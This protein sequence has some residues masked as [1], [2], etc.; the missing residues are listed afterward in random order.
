MASESTTA[1]TRRFALQDMCVNVVNNKTTP[2]AVLQMGLKATSP[3]KPPKLAEESRPP[4]SIE[5]AVNSPVPGEARVGGR[6]RELVLVEGAGGP[7]QA[8]RFKEGNSAERGG[9]SWPAVTELEADIGSHVEPARHV[10]SH[11]SGVS[12]LP[13]RRLRMP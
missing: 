6:K 1:P 10:R 9:S 5:G 13:I 3:E 4:K 2:S 12:T 11:D 7:S 8:K